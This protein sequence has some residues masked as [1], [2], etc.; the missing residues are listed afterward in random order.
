MI[1]Q[2]F[3]I[4]T[5]LRFR[6]YRKISRKSRIIIEKILGKPRRS[7]QQAGPCVHFL[8]VND[9]GRQRIDI[10]RFIVSEQ[11]RQCDRK[12]QKLGFPPKGQGQQADIVGRGVEQVV[13]SAMRSACRTL[14]RVLFVR[15]VE[16]PARESFS[17]VPRGYVALCN[18]EGCRQSRLR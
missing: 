16:R 18:P 7:Y 6:K 8:N 11:R 14:R 9:T 15:L 12:A 4:V 1:L 3:V 5:I 17:R 2:I 13:I 10:S